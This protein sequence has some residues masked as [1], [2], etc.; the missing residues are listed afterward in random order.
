MSN[1]LNAL[2]NSENTFRLED[3]RTIITDRMGPWSNQD[4]TLAW[5]TAS[6]EPCVTPEEAEVLFDYGKLS[7]VQ[8]DYSGKLYMETTFC[9]IRTFDGAIVCGTLSPGLYLREEILEYARS[10][11][12]ITEEPTDV[13]MFNGTKSLNFNQN[14]TYKITYIWSEK[15]KSEATTER[16]YQFTK[17]YFETEFQRERHSFEHGQVFKVMYYS[18]PKLEITK[19]GFSIDNLLESQVFRRENID[20]IREYD[21]Q[22]GCLSTKI[23]KNLLL[24]GLIQLGFAYDLPE[25]LR[26]KYDASIKEKSPNNYLPLFQY[27]PK[28]SKDNKAVVLG[29][30]IA[31]YSY[32]T[33][34]HNYTVSYKPTVPYSEY[35]RCL[36]KN[37]ETLMKKAYETNGYYVSFSP[38][39]ES[40]YF[41]VNRKEEP[42]YSLCSQFEKEIVALDYAISILQRFNELNSHQL[43]FAI[44]KF[45]ASDTNFPYTE[46]FNFYY[47]HLESRLSEK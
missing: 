46:L 5:E 41:S 39:N 31:V 7:N 12:Y 40:V 4:L 26:I 47:S 15:I 32:S 20:A 45:Y 13:Q 42:G 28:L 23:D 24:K 1:Y 17:K 14:G 18:N 6:G 44:M 21:L 2:L 43:F 9:D 33:Q 27:T 11:G 30:G 37:F 38:F 34:F 36:M 3:K 19:D 10:K 22:I 16:L 35:V 29:S 8:R 25:N